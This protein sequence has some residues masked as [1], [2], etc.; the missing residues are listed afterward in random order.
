MTR[1]GAQCQYCY[2]VPTWCRRL[3]RGR[4]RDGRRWFRCRCRCG[5]GGGGGGAGGGAPLQQG[6]GGRPGDSPGGPS[7]H[8]VRLLQ[9]VPG[10]GGRRRLH[11]PRRR[12]SGGW[13]RLG[14]LTLEHHLRQGG[15]GTAVISRQWFTGTESAVYTHTIHQYTGRQLSRQLDFALLG[16]PE[17]NCLITSQ[18]SQGWRSALD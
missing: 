4:C 7:V 2:P 16:A 18:A 14:R 9:T 1:K 6:F 3:C 8:D 11:V 15:R 12:H 10:E 5:G 13:V 17:S